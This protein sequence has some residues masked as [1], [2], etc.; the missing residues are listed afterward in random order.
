MS[1]VRLSGRERAILRERRLAAGLR[2]VDL[3]RRGSLSAEHLR[4]IERG[5]RHPSV[6]TLQLI[7]GMLADQPRWPGYAL[8]PEALRWL[9]AHPPPPPE[10]PA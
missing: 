2:I 7:E 3:A 1:G 6:A 9:H 8:T 4:S 5:S 10:V